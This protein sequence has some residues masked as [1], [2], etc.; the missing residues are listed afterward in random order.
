MMVTLDPNMA[1]E[2]APR[3]KLI[4]ACGLLP[5]F[6]IDS[7]TKVAY[8]GGEGAQAV[9]DEMVTLYGF[10]DYSGPSWGTVSPSGSYVSSYEE[11]EDLEPYL[12]MES[13]EGVKMYVYPNAI[14]AVMDSETTIL[15]RM[16]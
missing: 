1:Y 10:G 4:E 13:L 3:G 6:F 5:N 2:K 12:M 8:E 14:L 15:T 11:D 7:L 16:D 9:Y